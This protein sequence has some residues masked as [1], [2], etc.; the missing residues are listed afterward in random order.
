MHNFDVTSY[1]DLFKTFPMKYSSVKIKIMIILALTYSTFTTMRNG[2]IWLFSTN[3]KLLVGDYPWSCI[4]TCLC[5]FITH[6]KITICLYSNSTCFLSCILSSNFNNLLFFN[7]EQYNFSFTAS[8]HITT[9]TC[10]FS[11]DAVFNV[12]RLFTMNAFSEMNTI[13]GDSP[14]CSLQ[15][16]N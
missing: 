16:V 9:E 12:L 1:S 6:T 8:C 10:S 11:Y 4:S 13:P 3:Q 7:N 5:C 15:G 14:W 2:Q